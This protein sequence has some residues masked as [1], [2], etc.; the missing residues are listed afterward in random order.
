MQMSRDTVLFGRWQ[1]EEL[2]GSGLAGVTWR[3]R[4]LETGDTVAIKSG[5]RS[6][7]H[8]AEL[9]TTLDH[10]HVV[11]CRAVMYEAGAGDPVLVTDCVEGGDLSRHISEHGPYA[12]TAAARLGLQLVDALETLH[13]LDVLHRD[14]KP[15]NVL[16]TP[17]EDGLPLLQVCDFGISRRLKDGEVRVTEVVVTRGYSPPEQVGGGTLT[18]ASDLYALGACLRYMAT[19]L[20]P[21][22]EGDRGAGALEPLLDGLLCADPAARPSLD[23]VRRALVEVVEGRGTLVPSAPPVAGW[24]RRVAWGVLGLGGAVLLFVLLSR[25]PSEPAPSEAPAARAEGPAVVVEPQPDPVQPP[26]VVVARVEA[27][28]EPASATTDGPATAPP[29]GAPEPPPPEVRTEATAANAPESSTEPIA[30][31]VISYPQ[32]RVLVDGQYVRDTVLKGI[33]LDLAPGRHSVRLEVA[34]DH[35]TVTLDLAPGTPPQR[36]CYHFQRG[37]EC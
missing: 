32:A 18:A 11:R 31:T 26:A 22:E 13:A 29:P 33:R 35:H 6:L 21:D 23:A 5:P 19:G 1:L 20:H 34:G 37:S 12:P 10:P 16:V 7:F 14:L 24:W 27:A 4:D 3:A 36:I 30:L 25:G 9:L 15:H 17:R 8:E 2:L 28:P